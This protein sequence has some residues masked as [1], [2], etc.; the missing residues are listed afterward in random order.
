ME[1]RALPVEEGEKFFSFYTPFSKFSFEE[2]QEKFNQ[3]ILTQANG[4]GRKANVKVWSDVGVNGGAN[5]KVLSVRD[6]EEMWDYVVSSRFVRDEIKRR[7]GYITGISIEDLVRDAYVVGM[8][9]LKG[10][11]ES[12]CCEEC[13]SVECE[14]WERK[15]RISFCKAL[16]RL[17]DL[18]K[19]GGRVNYLEVVKEEE[20]G[21][22]LP[23]THRKDWDLS[24][25][26]KLDPL[27]IL[28]SQEEE[29]EKKSKNEERLMKVRE[30]L[31]KLK[32]RER[33]VWELLL[34]GVE[35]R[36]VARRLGYKRVQGVYMVIRRGVKKIRKYLAKSLK[37]GKHAR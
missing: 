14:V 5:G 30:A 24:A 21:E 26:W 2:D 11:R 29:E 7:H 9:V 31:K 15:F 22:K 13:L 27:M 12:N 1:A 36:E 37:D 19:R 25:N 17:Q 8:E 20:R 33:E 4:D 35:P 28:C 23:T 32:K 16:R 3:A 18:R 34:S 6:W 10:C